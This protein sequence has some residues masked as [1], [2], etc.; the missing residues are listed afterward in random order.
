[1]CSYTS[2][3]SSSVIR[4]LGAISSQILNSHQTFRLAVQLSSSVVYKHVLQQP[5][6]Y[7]HGL[8]YST[9]FSMG[10]IFVDWT[11]CRNNFCGLRIVDS[12]THSDVAAAIY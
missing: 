1:M 8:L 7:R 9:K 10:K 5:L 4:D 2:T 11:F 12:H 3:S 6:K